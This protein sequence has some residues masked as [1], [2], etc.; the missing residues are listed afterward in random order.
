MTDNSKY[1]E[2]QQRVTFTMRS[3]SARWLLTSINES[4][5][6][7]CSKKDEVD[8]FIVGNHDEKE[9]FIHLTNFIAFVKNLV[10][11]REGRGSTI[12]FYFLDLVTM[13]RSD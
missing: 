4:I 8:T 3:N 12:N 6:R 9:E 5:K 7:K 10:Y 1:L 2:N 11:N 13:K